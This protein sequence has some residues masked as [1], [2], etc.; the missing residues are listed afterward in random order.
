[1]LEITN[2]LS[3]QWV[4]TKTKLFKKEDIIEMSL[5]LN[6][7]SIKDLEKIETKTTC[8]EIINVKEKID[9]LKEKLE[10]HD[11]V[12][13][14]YSS[15]D[16]EDYNFF[17]FMVYVINKIKKNITI[18]T[19][20]VGEIP[21]TEKL[22]YGPSWSISCYS[23]DEIREIMKFEKQLTTEEIDDISIEW[24]KLENENADLRIIEKQ[25]LKSANYKFLDDIVLEELSKCKEMDENRLIVNLMLR[26]Q[27][28]HDVGG[29]NGQII[30]QYRI[31]ELKKQ[32][33]IKVVR[34]RLELN[35]IKE[36][37]KRIVI[38]IAKNQINN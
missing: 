30:F 32:N 20:N 35:A 21:K 14:W 6:V 16:S 3:D 4:L 13:I 29:I 23:E 36:L 27:E 28:N 19:I 1:M 8:N 5:L 22:K 34:T 33:K 37:E 10:T 9:K 24:I 11:T 38:K 17:T 7:G 26:E 18:K 31:N 2:G 12:R 25:G 15:M